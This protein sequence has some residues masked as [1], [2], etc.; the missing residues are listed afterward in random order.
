MIRRTSL[1]ARLTAAYSLAVLLVLVGA[2]TWVALRLRGDLD[3]RVDEDLAARGAAS[4]L[5]RSDL[6]PQST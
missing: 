1:L 5:G 4:F 3:D 6:D 2:S